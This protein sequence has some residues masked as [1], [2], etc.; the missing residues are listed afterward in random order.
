[1]K[2][3]RKRTLCKERGRDIEETIKRKLRKKESTIRKRE[4]NRG[5]DEEQRTE[6]L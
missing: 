1:M 6:K 5:M 3:K 2:S 4:R